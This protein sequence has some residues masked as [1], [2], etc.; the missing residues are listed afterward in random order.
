MLKKVC[1]LSASAAIAMAM[2]TVRL[3]SCANTPLAE[4]YI[5]SPLLARPDQDWD[6]VR[7]FNDI[8]VKG[9]TDPSSQ[10]RAPVFVLG[11][12]INGFHLPLE[13]IEKEENI[14]ID[15]YMQKHRI[16]PIGITKNLTLFL[17]QE[18]QACPRVIDEIL[19]A[20][21]PFKPQCFKIFRYTSNTTKGLLVGNVRRDLVLRF[22]AL[23]H[24][25]QTLKIFN[26]SFTTITIIIKKYTIMMQKISI[27]CNPHLKSLIIMFGENN[28]YSWMDIQNLIIVKNHVLKHVFV[29]QCGEQPPWLPPSFDDLPATPSTIPEGPVSSLNIGR[30]NLADLPKVIS[31]SLNASQHM[32]IGKIA[33]YD[34]TIFNFLFQVSSFEQ[35]LMY[36]RV[37]SLV[38]HKYAYQIKEMV[39]LTKDLH[40]ILKNEAIRRKILPSLEHIKAFSIRDYTGTVEFTNGLSHCLPNLVSL[41]LS[42]GAPAYPNREINSTTEKAGRKKNAPSEGFSIP[43]VGALTLLHLA[44][45]MFYI[46]GYCQATFVQR[47]ELY[48]CSQAYT[49]AVPCLS[50]LVCLQQLETNFETLLWMAHFMQGHGLTVQ[51]KLTLREVTTNTP[52]INVIGLMCIFLQKNPNSQLDVHVYYSPTREWTESNREI[53]NRCILQQG[54]FPTPSLLPCLCRTITL[55]NCSPTTLLCSTLEA[56]IALETVFLYTHYD[57]SFSSFIHFLSGKD[58]KRDFLPKRIV[59][60]RKNRVDQ[61]NIYKYQ[62]WA[63]LTHLEALPLI[64]ESLDPKLLF[65][66]DGAVVVGCIATLKHVFTN[67]H[68]EINTPAQAIPTYTSWGVDLP[69]MKPVFYPEREIHWCKVTWFSKTHN[70]LLSIQLFRRSNRGFGISVGDPVWHMVMEKPGLVL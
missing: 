25:P 14:H 4:G 47:I 8:A 2:Q 19:S 52:Y 29:G 43:K 22:D 24:L 46:I 64:F 59:I 27:G 45:S 55:E 61:Q 11:V 42:F 65:T 54:P 63:P 31:I 70:Q 44:P 50:Q 51:E 35:Y 56:L 58:I 17:S 26:T 67:I 53:F 16:V 60:A 18:L 28:L 6:I 69:H 13:H 21:E 34:C 5:G 9:Y 15:Q 32:V 1:Y 36:L 49:S 57:I 62:I 41:E 12:A 30:L 10:A 48:L 40:L 66:I 7:V 38:I 3:G 33:Q 68:V 37:E 39:A 20:F 23:E